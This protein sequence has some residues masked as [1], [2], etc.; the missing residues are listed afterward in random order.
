LFPVIFATAD[1]ASTS[2]TVANL[3][4]GRLCASRSKRV[5]PGVPEERIRPGKSPGRFKRLRLALAEGG[6]GGRC[7]AGAP[8]APS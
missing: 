3:P 2:L 1:L 6:K 4:G 7:R 5:P 8:G